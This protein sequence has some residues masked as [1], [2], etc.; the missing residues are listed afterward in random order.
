[1]GELNDPLTIGK[2]YYLFSSSTYLYHAL[3]CISP[4]YLIHII[5]NSALLAC[6]SDNNDITLQWNQLIQVYN[7]WYGKVKYTPENLNQEHKI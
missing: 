6:K 5:Y 7:E 1:M 2:S 4:V 3:F